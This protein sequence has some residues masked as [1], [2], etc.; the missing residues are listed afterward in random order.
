MA[1]LAPPG[2]GSSVQVTLPAGWDAPAAVLLASCNLAVPRGFQFGGRGGFLEL[3]DGTS[4]EL[5]I[6]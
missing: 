1:A 6:H 2:N 5:K 3:G 4:G